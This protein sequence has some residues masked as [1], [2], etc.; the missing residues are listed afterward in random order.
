L[1][2]LLKVAAVQPP[3]ILDDGL[4]PDLKVIGFST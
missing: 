1:A 4:K 2:G 3:K